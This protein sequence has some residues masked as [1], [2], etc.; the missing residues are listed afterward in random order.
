[1][2]HLCSCHIKGRRVLQHFSYAQESCGLG[3]SLLLLGWQ[4]GAHFPSFVVSL[5]KFYVSA[6]KL[7][8]KS[9]YIFEYT[10]NFL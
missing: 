10:H 6:R 9:T 3:R 7:S 8:R 1:M 5:A 2:V 4:A